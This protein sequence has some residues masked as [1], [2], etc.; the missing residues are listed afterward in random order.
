MTISRRRFVAL[1]AGSAGS[2][3]LSS[4]RDLF[5]A[6]APAGKLD[7]L[8]LGGTKF[9]GPAIVDAALARGHKVT[10]FNRGRTNTHLYP[11][12]EKIKGDRD[13]K[14]DEGLK[15]LVGRRFDCVFDDNGYYPRIVGASAQLCAKNGCGQYIYTSSISAYRDNKKAGADEDY[16]V[17]T[18]AD[19]TLETMG[20]NFEHY[21]ALKALCEAAARDAFGARATIVR[22]GYIVG[23]LDPT[24]RFTFYPVRAAK[25]GEM[26]APGAPSDPLQ[27]IDVRDLGAFMVRLAEQRTPGVFNGCGPAKRLTIGEVIEESLAQTGRKATP[28]WVPGAFL[29]ERG[30]NGEGKIPIW[31]PADGETQGYHTWSNARAIKAGLTFRPLAETMKDTLAWFRSLPADRQAALKAGL[32]E[33]E[34]ADLIAAWR[35]TRKAG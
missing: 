16:P 20:P 19:P 18:M 13:P 6:A 30:E 10:L 33:K 25:G 11:Q 12:L 32:S 15:G 24:D 9:L 5:A 35:A 7:I 26:L 28:V 8:V 14:K 29:R 22:P 21:G 23:P 17:A 34:E 2:L 3:A 1:A 4:P 31:A 27:I